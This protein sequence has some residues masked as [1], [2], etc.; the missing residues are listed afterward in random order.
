M[1]NFQGPKN[2]NNI[3]CMMVF[4]IH[5]CLFA[6][7]L[8]IKFLLASLKSL[9]NRESPSNNPLQEVVPAFR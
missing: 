9:S 6:K 2:K 5:V 3:F 1:N 7:K 4:T 8:K